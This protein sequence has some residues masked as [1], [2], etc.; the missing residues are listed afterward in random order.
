MRRDR[1][2][3]IS[4]RADELG[5]HCSKCDRASASVFVDLTRRKR[6]PRLLCG[7]CGSGYPAEFDLCGEQTVRVVVRRIAGISALAAIS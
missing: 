3:R 1:L 2:T 5:L 6:P 4:A 7:E